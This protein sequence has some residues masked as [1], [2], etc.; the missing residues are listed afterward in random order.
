[1]TTRD[2]LHQLVDSL[3]DHEIDDAAKYITHLFYARDPLLNALLEAPEDDELETEEERKSM[4]EAYED[5]KSG[6]IVPKSRLL[7]EN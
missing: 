6:N 4:K 1:M 2:N 5:L 3:E 7:D